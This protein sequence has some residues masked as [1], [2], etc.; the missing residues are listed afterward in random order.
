MEQVLAALE[1]VRK[2]APEGNQEVNLV[3]KKNIVIA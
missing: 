2:F 3:I 1:M